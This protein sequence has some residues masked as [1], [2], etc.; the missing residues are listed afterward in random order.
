MDIE[1]GNCIKIRSRKYSSEILKP[2]KKSAIFL[3]SK[4][5]VKSKVSPQIRKNPETIDRYFLLSKKHFH[6]VNKLNYLNKIIPQDCCTSNF[7]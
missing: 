4:S 3:K 6:E 5:K 1:A 2:T 7:D